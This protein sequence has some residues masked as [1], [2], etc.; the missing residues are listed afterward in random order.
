[1]APEP[2]LQ[3]VHSY[4][5]QNQSLQEPVSDGMIQSEALNQKHQQLA[6]NYKRNF[7]KFIWSFLVNIWNT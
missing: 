7:K 1:M 6:T 4:M 5:G 3:I 2:Q